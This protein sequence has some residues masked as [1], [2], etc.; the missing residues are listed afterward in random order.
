LGRIVRRGEVRWYTFK[1]PDK[2]RPVLIL[3]RNSAIGFLYACTVA[4]ITTT[5]RDIP[6]EVRLTPDDGLLTHCAANMDNIQTVPK[7]KL[8]SMIAYLSLDKMDEVNQAIS[9]AL[10]FDEPTLA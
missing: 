8:G 4:P 3:T 6:S 10:G 2:R 1:A 5:I 9:F 7:H